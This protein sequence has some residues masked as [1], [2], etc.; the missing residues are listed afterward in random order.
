MLPGTRGPSEDVPGAPGRSHLLPLRRPCGQSAAGGG[1]R[2][3][4]GSHL[5]HFYHPSC[6]H[7]FRVSCVS[8]AEEGEDMGATVEF[9]APDGGVDALVL[10]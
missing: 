7:T 6:L 10:D 3:A 1:G 8:G 5:Q 9:C 4:A 2:R